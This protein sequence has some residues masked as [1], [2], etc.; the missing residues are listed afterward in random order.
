MIIYTSVKK[1]LIILF[2]LFF[3]FLL[4]NNKKEKY[5]HPI[6]ERIESPDILN[7]L[8]SK[9]INIKKIYCDLQIKQ[10]IGSIK[11]F[12][13][14][15]KPNNFKMI[16]SSIFSKELEIGS[17]N[18]YFWFYIRTMKPKGLYYCD[19]KSIEKTR[20]R[21]IFYPSL[22]NSFIGINQITNKN[23]FKTEDYYYLKEQINIGKDSYSKI[24]II[25][26]DK[27]IGYKFCNNDKILLEV[28][29]IEFQNIKGLYLPQ[30]I[31]INWIEESIKQEWTLSKIEINSNYNEWEM[32]NYK[33]KINLI[34]Y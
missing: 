3:I 16:G 5:F 9:L 28:E 26:N 7:N 27:I 24:T 8:N 1:F 25:K 21:K 15:E 34:D 13:A 12:I 29:I 14:Y 17:N 19:L 23:L 30:K 32:P 33:N 20:L 2:F 6:G 18:N 31:K 22:L 4:L 11:G 10:G